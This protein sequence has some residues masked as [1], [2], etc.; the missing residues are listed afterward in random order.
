MELIDT[1]CHVA[2]EQFNADRADV[3]ARAHTAGVTRILAVA[4]CPAE[5]PLYLK[6]AEGDPSLRVA[7]GLHPNNAVSFSPAGLAE[8]GRLLKQHVG[9]A[10]AVGEIGLD[11]YRRHAT[12]GQQL[13]VLRAQLELAAELDLPVVLHCRQAEGQLLAALEAHRAACGRPLRGVW[14]SFSAGPGHA[15]EAVASGLHLGFNGILTYP[16]A[17]DVRRAAR[18][19]PA[20]RLLLETD[21]PYLP[22]QPWRGR[23]C[24][25]AYLVETARRM[26]QL[27]GVSLEEVAA[28]T[29][30]NAR[31]LF[32]CW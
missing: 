9:S 11:F 14:H 5:W 12:P 23:R 20:D 7:L 19:V 26:A 15:R 22:P 27:R 13:P 32:G 2:D 6:L 18:E 3:L 30:G 1:H 21:A 10:V 4:T 29:T 16:K 17:E 24:E 31:K 8:L 25:P 28:Q